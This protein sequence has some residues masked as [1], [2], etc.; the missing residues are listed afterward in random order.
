MRAGFY[1]VKGSMITP[2]RAPVLIRQ[3][4]CDFMLDHTLYAK[5]LVAFELFC[6]RDARTRALVCEMCC[7]AAEGQMAW[8]EARR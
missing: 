3:V 2:G 1:P 6:G 4:V 8:R 5:M 7:N